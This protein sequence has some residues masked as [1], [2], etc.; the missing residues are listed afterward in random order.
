M[1]LWV[2]G[3]VVEN[4][5]KERQSQGVKYSRICYVGDGGN[6]Y[7]PALRLSSKDYVFARANYALERRLSY[8]SEVKA[9]VVIW[10][11]GEIILET[12]KS[13]K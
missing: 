7:C 9:N 8:S 4:H 3:Q 6:D 13:F 10:N 2:V 1:F 11:S 5:I 12:L